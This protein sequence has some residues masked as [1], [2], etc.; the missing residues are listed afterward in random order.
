MTEDPHFESHLRPSLTTMLQITVKLSLRR[1]VIATAAKRSDSERIAFFTSSSSW[2]TAAHSPSSTDRPYSADQYLC[3]TA[4]LYEAH[5][6]PVGLEEGAR[7][8]G[9][10]ATCFV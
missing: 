9:K 8:E 1:S 3:S 5:M 4:A 2:L 7:K 6:L 10:K